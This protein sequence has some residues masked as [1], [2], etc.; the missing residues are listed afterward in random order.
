MIDRWGI[1]DGYEDCEGRWRATSPRTH[2]ALVAAMGGELPDEVPVRVI[3]P[4]EHR[5]VQGPGELRYEDGG[6]FRLKRFAPPDLPLGYH[7]VHRP[8]GRIERIIVTPRRCRLD[9]RMRAWGWT[10]QLYAL[11]SRR[12]WGMGDLGDLRDL[13]AWSAR[14]LGARFLVMNPVFASTPKS[15]LEPSPYYPGS[16][17]FRNP[18][19]LRV[20]D[21]PGASSA[22]RDLEPLATAGRALNNE[23]RI[24]RD[25]I[26]RLKSEAL[27]LLGSRFPGDPDFDLYCWREGEALRQF[28]VFCSLAEHFHGGWRSWPSQYHDPRSR[29]V[30][31]FASEHAQRVQFYQW[32][33]W[34]LDRQMAQAARE[35]ALVEDLPVGIDADGPDAWVWQSLLAQGA[36]MGAPPDPYSAA[37]QDWQLPPFIPH[38]LRAAGYGPFIDTVRAAMRYAG[39]LRIDHVMGLFRL[40]WIPE[41]AGPADGA[42][43]H[44]PAS[45]LLDIVALE[46][47]RAG[48]FVVGEDLGT[49][50]G[51]VRQELAARAIL[52]T[53]LLWFEDVPPQRYPEQALAGVTTH[54]LPTAAGLWTGAD[55]AEQRALGR[56]PGNGPHEMRERMRRLAGK[57]DGAG[58]R[59][60]I[61]ELHRQ[62]ARAPS[63]AVTATLE[64]ALAV[65]RRPNIPSSTTDERPN[66]SLALPK[67]LEEI[68]ADPQV[69][70]LAG[71][72]QT[73][74]NAETT[75]S[76]R[77]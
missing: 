2:A 64:D 22:L 4:G 36:R 72:L 17:R 31:F 24:D 49:V 60:V 39:G 59:E 52:S 29:A 37:G 21:V 9:P 13:A 7:E 10:A 1:A 14:E 75:L 32:L 26:W 55:A 35:V 41:G 23:R 61:L 43:V 63:V 66:W 53:R 18:L 57:A 48:A 15:P 27:E 51:G 56:D 62:L 16:R 5:R 40:F 46:S 76:D 45:D 65:E 77:R 30:T 50:E 74:R 71:A 25:R 73:C 8:D 68:R 11:R 69:R 28:A 47:H 42:Y 38:R 6:V 12:S 54:D 3:A 20:E 58:L 33:Q 44:Y 67:T 19:Y 70:A 34:L